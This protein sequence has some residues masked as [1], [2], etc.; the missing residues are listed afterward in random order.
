MK[1]FIDNNLSPHL[2]RALNELCAGQHSVTHLREKFDHSTDDVTWINTLAKEG[3]W[4]I[5]TQDRLSKGDMEKEAI[6]RSGLTVFILAKQ[7]TQ[8]KSWEKAQKLVHW[9][10]KIIEQS[11]MVEAGAAFEIPCKPATHKARFKTRKL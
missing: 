4:V 7:W 5:V 11:E 6:R 8:I 10:P 9:W 1:F 3:N 2:A